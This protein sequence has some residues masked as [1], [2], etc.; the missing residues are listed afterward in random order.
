LAYSTKSKHVCQEELARK[1]TEIKKVENLPTFKPKKQL[2]KEL[3]AVA[4]E[5]CLQKFWS[6]HSSATRAEKHQTS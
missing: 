4:T 6:K 3:T 1:W 5:R 2:I